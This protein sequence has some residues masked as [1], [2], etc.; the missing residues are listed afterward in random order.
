MRCKPVASTPPKLPGLLHPEVIRS[1]LT[2]WGFKM[3][4]THVCMDALRW[5]NGPGA[6]AKKRK[7][8]S[9]ARQQQQCWKKDRQRREKERRTQNGGPRRAADWATGRGGAHQT[10][11][12]RGRKR[13]GRRAECE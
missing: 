12:Q 2:D 13:R 7:T 5:R 4:C 10:R 1:L 9:R 6:R 8:K 3:T 11:T